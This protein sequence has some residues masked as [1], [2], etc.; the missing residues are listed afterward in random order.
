MSESSGVKKSLLVGGVAFAVGSLLT[1]QLL[2]PEVPKPK[3]RFV[4]AAL[5]PVQTET[6]VAE[7]KAPQAELLVDAPL[8]PKA[9]ETAEARFETTQEDPALN[10]ADVTLDPFAAPEIDER[11]DSAQVSGLGQDPEIEQTETVSKPLAVD[12]PKDAPTNK[13]ILAI[14]EEAV[15]LSTDAAAPEIAVAEE[16]QEVSA[17]VIQAVN[18]GQSDDA[19]AEIIASA[20]DTGKI[21]APASV[22]QV[23]GTV[24]TRSLLIT[25][26]EKAVADGSE[27]AEVAAAQIAKADPE[28]ADTPRPNGRPTF[29][30]V[31]PGDS[32]AAIAYRF[33]GSTSEF[34][35]IFQANAASIKDPSRIFVGQ[36]LKIPG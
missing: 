4:D 7:V 33:Y 18:E 31:Q 22:F 12:P 25:L 21:T 19:I 3:P 32:L 28:R 15:N 17:K 23:D 13:K 11:T 9:E 14:L 5:I 26:V 8:L 30:I 24:D 16:E 2:G 10:L 34:S 35:K 36:R 6:S 27:D 20:L 29:Y 1:M